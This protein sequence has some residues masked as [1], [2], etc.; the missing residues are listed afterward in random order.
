[1][2][3]KLRTRLETNVHRDATTEASVREDNFVEGQRTCLCENGW[4]QNMA[5]FI[6]CWDIGCSF[7]GRGGEL[8]RPPRPTDGRAGEGAR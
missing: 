4:V 5:P 2:I 3:T 6:G 7:M 1:V 8:L